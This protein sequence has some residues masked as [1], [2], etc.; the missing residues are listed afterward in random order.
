[1]R[2][3]ASVWSVHLIE[4]QAAQ[5]YAVVQS[6]NATMCRVVYLAQFQL[7]RPSAAEQVTHLFSDRAITSPNMHAVKCVLATCMTYVNATEHHTVWQRIE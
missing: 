7:L 6:S 1:M 2:Q 3:C 5:W 4:G